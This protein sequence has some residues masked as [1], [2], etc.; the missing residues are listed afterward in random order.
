MDLRSYYA[1]KGDA[2]VFTEQAKKFTWGVHFLDT[3]ISME[4]KGVN[5]L[6]TSMDT[7]IITGS[8]VCD[9]AILRLRFETNGKQYNLLAVDTPV[10]DF[11]GNS[12]NVPIYPDWMPDWL[13]RF[14]EDP[15]CFFKDIANFFD[16]A[17]PVIVAIVAVILIGI[18]CYCFKSVWSI[19]KVVLK[20]VTFPFVLVFKLLK[21]IFG[22]FTKKKSY[23]KKIRNPN[24]RGGW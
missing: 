2:F 10:D 16:N 8:G 9:T 3:D 21:G 1:D 12:A 24:D 7:N 14:L 11:K 22:L 18:L 17:F 19:V 13:I 5:S 23:S 6:G 4:Y 15:L 20:V